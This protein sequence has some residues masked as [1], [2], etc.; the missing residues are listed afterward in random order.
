M[1]LII[2]CFTPFFCD[3]QRPVKVNPLNEKGSRFGQEGQE[4]EGEEEDGERDS[5]PESNVK[6]FRK[7]WVWE[8]NGVYKRE[9]P[10]DT[11][12]RGIHN[13][14]YIYQQS[15]ANTYLAN[16]PSPYE[17]EVF[18]FREQEQD[19]SPLNNIRAFL[20]KPEDGLHYNSTTPFTQLKYF[21]GG[22]K[23]KNETMLDVWHAQN[24][25]PYW[26]AG[27][28]YNLLSSDG[29]YMNQRSK[30]YN[31]SF[32]SSYELDRVAASFFVNQNNGHFNENGGVS[33][34]NIV[35]DSSWNAEDIPVNL[36]EVKNSYRNFNFNAQFQY[37]IGGRRELIGKTDTSYSYPA[38]A[39]MTL[40]VEDN[41]HRFRENI[42][43]TDFFP[44]SYI[45]SVKN[46][47]VQSNK[48]YHV[49]TKF[50]LNE[51]PRLKYLPG[52]YAGLDFKYLDYTGRTS[53]DTINNYGS[54]KY[55]G[56][57]LTA[58]IFNVDTNATF[59]FDVAARLCVLGDYAGNFNLKGYLQQYLSRK[60]SSYVRVDANIELKNAS[61]FFTRFVG[62]HAYWVN[63]FKAVKRLDVQGKYVNPRL[64]TEV[65]VGLSN[66]F[67]YIYFDT[68][69]LPVQNG[70]NLMVLTG[71]VKQNFRAGK[72]YFD[73]TV[74]CQ[75]SSDDKVLSLPTIAVYSHNY[76]QNH[77]FKKA[78]EFNIGFDMY[79]NTAFYADN[80]SVSTMQFYNQRT[81]RTGN[82]PKFDVFVNFRV[83]RM[84]IF[85]KYEHVNYY[86]TN[87]E[88]FSALDYPINPAM[89]KFGL[90]W[91]FFD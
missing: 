58:G 26:N 40:T 5:I 61:H 22:G 82:Y 15:I 60:D 65:G 43:N 19:F 11:L 52:A 64:R 66:T 70:K 34:R 1:Y 73:Q 10:L 56:T 59:N 31:M 18:I 47:D 21:T 90:R 85:A 20:F 16:F 13:Y 41:E 35:R 42:V 81:E 87:G 29:R 44:V 79:Y 39:V 55:T 77:L 14:N 51:H 30:A 6:H 72:F 84:D 83:K 49:S 89:F 3:G 28:R 69:A 32:F 48:V 88:Y 36:S 27:F 76:Y 63:D 17:S 7:T 53:L 78:L 24:I 57:Y 23:G 50:M 91:N 46:V 37:N 54:T 2:L 62:N 74:Y 68:S 86:I 12:F 67:E 71:W 9:V 38:K 33:D 80:Y 75:K 8:H 25:R 4:R 45:D